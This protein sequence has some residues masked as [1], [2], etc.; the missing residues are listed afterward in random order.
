MGMKKKSSSRKQPT[1]IGRLWGSVACGGDDLT[2]LGKQHEQ[3]LDIEGLKTKW[4]G[5]M[6]GNEA[7]GHCNS[8]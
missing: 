2:D 7:L 1:L 5:S 6:V 8:Q 4:L 3:G